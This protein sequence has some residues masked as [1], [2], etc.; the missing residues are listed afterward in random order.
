[1][2]NSV[3]I[4]YE[5][6][7]GE[8]R[9]LQPVWAALREQPRGFVLTDKYWETILFTRQPATWFEFDETFERNIMTNAANFERYVTQHPIRY[10]IL[11]TEHGLASPEVRAYLTT[12]ARRD[13]FGAYVLYSL[14]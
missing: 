12:H 13:V 11:P 1:V 9:A 5:A 8:L 14:R 4:G 6:R 3:T 10:V 7:A 2:I